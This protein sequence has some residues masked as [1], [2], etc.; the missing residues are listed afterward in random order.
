MSGPS[1]IGVMM[2]TDR[3]PAGAAAINDRPQWA[4]CGPWAIAST[5][6]SIHSIRA[7]PGP[8]GTQ[9]AAASKAATPLPRPGQAIQKLAFLHAPLVSRAWMCWRA[10]R[11]QYSCG[12]SRYSRATA[13]QMHSAVSTRVEAP[14]GCNTHCK[15]FPK[16]RLGGSGRNGIPST[17]AIISIQQTVEN[18]RSCHMKPPLSINPQHRHAFHTGSY[19]QRPSLG[20]DD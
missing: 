2:N 1:V 8:S 19:R 6:H 13:Q 3:E 4:Q 12:Y 17:A 14:G 20:P 9:S 16:G 11:V 5:S 15:A 10:K 7:A 18:I